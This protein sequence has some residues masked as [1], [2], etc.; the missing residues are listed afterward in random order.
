MADEELNMSEHGNHETEVSSMG[1]GDDA[2]EEVKKK[3]E[4]VR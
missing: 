3:A 1:M 2:P 4:E